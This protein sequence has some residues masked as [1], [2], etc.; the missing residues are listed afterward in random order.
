MKPSSRLFWLVA[1]G[2]RPWF[3]DGDTLVVGRGAPRGAPSPRLAALRT[4]MPRRFRFELGRANVEWIEALIDDGLDVGVEALWV[5]MNG[6][7]D[8]PGRVGHAEATAALELGR[9]PALRELD[10][11]EYELL[12]NAC[13]W[14]GTLGRLDGLLERLPALRTLRLYG[15]FTL[16]GPADLPCLETLEVLVD[17]QNLALEVSSLDARTVESLLASRAPVLRHASIEPIGPDEDDPVYRL[18]EAFLAGRSMPALES[19]HLCGR[20]GRGAAA[21]VARALPDAKL[22]GSFL[23]GRVRTLQ[24]PSPPGRDGRKALG[25]DAVRLDRALRERAVEHVFFLA[26]GYHVSERGPTP[27]ERE[28]LVQA[29]P[30]VLPTI[31]ESYPHHRLVRGAPWRSRSVDALRGADSRSLLEALVAAGAHERV[32]TLRLGVGGAGSDDARRDLEACVRVLLSARWPELRRL[33]LGGRLEFR[34]PGLPDLV[35]DS[36]FWFGELGALGTAA[37]GLEHLFL[38]GDFTLAAPLGLPRL[39]TLHV[40]GTGA[41]LRDGLSQPTLDRLLGTGT[42]APVDVTLRLPMPPG[43]A[44]PP[45]RLPEAFLTDPNLAYLATLALGPIVDPAGLDRLEGARATLGAGLRVR[46]DGPRRAGS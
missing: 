40:A 30:H 24:R 5:G 25:R 9:W 19:L 22:A 31:A 2:E 43:A 11:G 41:P 13:D 46:L 42:M 6:D 44:A 8:F 4:G 26:N 39:E 33:K 17:T 18:P 14:H 45:L 16:D 12:C 15:H 7:A 21:A 20:F 37:P 27:R 1:R 28:D 32:S 36:R 34:A 38:G 29:D 23:F 3:V 10:L 35:P